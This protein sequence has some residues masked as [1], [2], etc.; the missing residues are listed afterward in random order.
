MGSETGVANAA[1]AAAA[2]AGNKLVPPSFTASTW[3][4]PES[5]LASV[6][7]TCPTPPALSQDT[8]DSAELMRGPA[9]AQADVGIVCSSTSSLSS[10]PSSDITFHLVP[11]GGPASGDLSS[12]KVTAAERMSKLASSALG[13]LYHHGG[14]RPARC[15]CSRDGGHG[16]L[17]LAGELASGGESAS[18]DHPCVCSEFAIETRTRSTV[19][20]SLVVAE[21]RKADSSGKS[22]GHTTLPIPGPCS[23][24]SCSDSSNWVSCW[25]WSG[26][27]AASQCTIAGNISHR[28][29][30][31][32]ARGCC[33][34]LP[35]E[36]SA[37]SFSAS[38]WR[39]AQSDLNSGR[40]SIS[41]SGIHF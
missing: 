37:S 41:S 23:D 11:R 16:V 40:R 34:C 24:A 18:R 10:E 14:R 5:P 31:I 3:I 29:L 4:K 32:F 19:S 15:C 2:G 36:P 21:K 13:T 26:G 7:M 20:R 1:V 25:C 17:G 28:F 39:T 8:L 33:E 9:A 30:C 22:P 38:H 6:V 35:S 27:A 12:L